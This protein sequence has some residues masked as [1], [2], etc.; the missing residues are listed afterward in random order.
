[1]FNE[2]L[3]D[4]WKARHNPEIPVTRQTLMAA[5]QNVQALYIRATYI[6]RAG[7]AKYES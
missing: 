1:M 2:F 5:L 4:F 6:E 7:Q 3:Q